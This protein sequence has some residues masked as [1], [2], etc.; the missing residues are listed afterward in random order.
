MSL[1]K[2]ELVYT[3]LT[4]ITSDELFMQLERELSSKNYIQDTWHDAIVERE[5]SY[6]TG[7]GFESVGIAIPHT[8]PIHIKNPYIAF[9]K[10]K[11][12]VVFDFMAGAGDPVSAEFV[13]NLG[14][15][16]E[17]DQVG[18]LQQLMGIFADEDCVEALRNASDEDQIFDLLESYLA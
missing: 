5:K 8:D 2:R 9:I 17:E 7:L 13:I 12:P 16:H 1:L 10:L 11:E 15:Q 3:T 18:L 14:I 6:P 4:P